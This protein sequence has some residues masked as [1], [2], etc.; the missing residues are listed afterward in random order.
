MVKMNLRIH[1]ASPFSSMIIFTAWLI[2]KEKSHVANPV[3]TTITLKRE[4]Y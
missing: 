3:A 4:S 2:I 1:D